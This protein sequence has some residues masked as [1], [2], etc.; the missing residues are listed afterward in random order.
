MFVSH[1]L[2]RSRCHDRPDMGDRW[3]KKAK[4]H[5]AQNIQ[6]LHL[7]VV[8]NPIYA[9]TS[10]APVNVQAT[11][12]TRWTQSQLAGATSVVHIS[13]YLWRL[14][15]LSFSPDLP[16]RHQVLRSALVEVLVSAAGA[17]VTRLRLSPGNSAS[18]TTRLVTGKTLKCLLSSFHFIFDLLLVWQL[19]LLYFWG[20]RF[21]F[22]PAWPFLRSPSG[23]LCSGRGDCECGECK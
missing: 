19:A 9:A 8:L 10:A 20:F 13:F 6:V 22:W 2:P 7:Y 1:I 11:T 3:G 23:E 18:A 12:Q 15:S 16:T 4:T 14:F 5:I 17:L 21:Q